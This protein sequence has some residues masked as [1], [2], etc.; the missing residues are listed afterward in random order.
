V[1]FVISRNAQAVREIAT[2]NIRPACAD[3]LSAGRYEIAANL[4]S[5]S[6]LTLGNPVEIDLKAGIELMITAGVAPSDNTAATNASNNAV[7]AALVDSV[8]EHSGVI[9]L[10]SAGLLLIGGIVLALVRR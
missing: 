3:G 9:V 6:R 2:S 8:V 7:V 4:P 10:A 1:L 5:D